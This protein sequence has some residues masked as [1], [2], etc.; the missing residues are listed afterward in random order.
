MRIYL[1]AAATKGIVVGRCLR[2]PI[3]DAPHVRLADELTR[4]GW[5]EPPRSPELRDGQD[6]RRL[7]PCRRADAIHPG[8]GSLAENAVV[9]RQGDRRR[10]H[11]DRPF[12]RSDPLSLGDRSK[13][14]DRR[15]GRCP[16]RSPAPPIRSSRRGNPRTPWTS[17]A[18]PSPSSGLRGGGRVHQKA[19]ASAKEI[20]NSPNPPCA[21][22]PP[23]SAAVRASIERFLDARAPRSRPS[24][25]PTPT[26][27]SRS[28]P[29]RD[30]LAPAPEPKTRR[31]SLGPVPLTEEQAAAASSISSKA[32]PEEGRRPRRGHPPVRRPGRYDPP[33]GQTP[34]FRP[35]MR[36]RKSCTS[37]SANSSAG[38]RRGSSAT[39]PEVR[40]HSIQFVPP[41]RNLARNFMPAPGPSRCSKTPTDPVSA[42]I[43]PSR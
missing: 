39:G 13:P 18:C 38:P 9:R 24:A 8:T 43:R 16:G 2:G 30:L 4:L 11:A 33:R 15:E 37:T 22:P 28:S 17:S 42:S 34:A 1:R 36:P 41:A 23:P 32:I 26:A 20:P 5:Q 35:S 14:P 3:R 21:R 19:G 27:T 25:W 12:P 31:G 10:H 6:H 40:G 7:P 29:S